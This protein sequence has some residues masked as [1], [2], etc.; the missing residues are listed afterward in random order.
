MVEGLDGFR[1]PP[2][3]AEIARRRPERLSLRQR[4]H[5]ERWGYPYVMDEFRFHLTLTGDLPPDEA[6]QVAAV[7]GPYF[8]P[9]LPRPFA[10]DSLC[11]FGQAED[12]RF[13]L[14]HRYT[15]SG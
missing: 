5:L 8:A 4:T 10:I 11:L 3:A 15:L 6:E 2:S 7:L 13:R 9:L 12:G 14:L 1:A